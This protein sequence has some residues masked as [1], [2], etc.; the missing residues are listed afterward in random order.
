[1]TSLLP[2]LI[3]L[4]ASPTLAGTPA[5]IEAE[6]SDD[7]RRVTGVFTAPPRLIASLVDPL[8][9]M[10]D[11]PD[12]RRM[13]RT[14]PGRPNGGAVTWTVT[15]PTTATFV[16][17]LPQ[18]YG[19][20]GWTREGL[21]ANGGWYPQPIDDGLPTLDWNVTVSIPTHA[22]GAL[23][24]RV[25]RDTLFWSGEAE[26]VS[27][28][29][30]PRGELTRLSGAHWQVDLVTP[31]RPRPVLL[32]ELQRSLDK[33]ATASMP[34]RGALIEGP[35]RRRLVRP[36]PG[37]AFVSDR[38]YRLTP[39]LQRF[40]RVAVT[41]GLVTSWNHEPDPF[42]RD[43]S[44]AA[45]GAEHANALAGA[46]AG[47][48]L[49]TF[50]WMPQVRGLLASATMPFYSDTLERTHPS[51]VIKDDLVEMWDPT[52]PGTVVLA[53]VSDRYGPNVEATVRRDISHGTAAQAAMGLAG[54]PEDFL[55]NW[56]TA[57]PKQDYVLDVHPKRHKVHVTRNAPADAPIEAAVVRIDGQ[58]HTIIGGPG[59]TVLDGLDGPH[60]VSLDPSGH[61]G[62]TSRRGDT[63]PAKYQLTFSA[64]ITHINATQFQVFGVGGMTLRKAYDTHNLWRGVL[65]NSFSDLVAARISYTR[66][67]GGL[68]DGWRRPHSMTLWTSTS[69][70]NPGFSDID[71]LQGS[72]GTGV[73]YSW[74]TRI[75]SD[76]PLRGHRFSL[77]VSGGLVPGLDETWLHQGLTGM[78]VVSPHPR[79]AIA[80]IGSITAAQ[81]NVPHRRL[82]LGGHAVMRSLPA[83][84][85][86]PSVDDDGQPIPCQE[87][88]DQR[89]F[90]AAEYRV[91]PLRNASVPGFLAWGSELQLTA[92]VE[93]VVANVD[94][95]VAEAVGVTVG[96][97]GLADLLGA[98]PYM[99]GITAGWPLWW[100]ASLT[101]VERHPWPE[102]YLRW[103]QE[104]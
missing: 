78:G 42:L 6:V 62:Q 104:F 57:Y 59:T 44:G 34:Q 49:R 11:A 18:R 7:L 89:A 76:F 90:G 21:L 35:L 12:D 73:S 95:R 22:V 29:V 50:S 86:C 61:L 51:D 55:Q 45:I 97:T 52:T 16:A 9:V 43:L 17:D 30:L 85:A 101:E 94:D 60:R 65:Y 79:H 81:S 37:L 3:A 58:D 96:I 56:R 2:V 5:R 39:G 99:G 77:G 48:L 64:G 98:E 54:I 82:R 1:M 92:G 14:F 4:A 75:S 40:H 47:K 63:W 33:T 13:F 88:A 69:L 83:L 53:Q 87:L 100:N 46:D 19:A 72:L 24:D 25:G 74:D 38:A 68:Q 41:R 36:G 70:L 71:G 23:G 10:P 80:A 28:G 31:R 32:R 67:E 91:A 93:G 20:L 66:K 103:A 26:R 8:S 27:L 84:A 102:L 15:G